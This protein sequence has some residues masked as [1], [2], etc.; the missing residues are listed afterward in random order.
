MRFDSRKA[1]RGLTTNHQQQQR[2][3]SKNRRYHRM[4]G[5]AQV[6]GLREVEFVLE[7]TNARSVHLAGDFNNWDVSGL[8]LQME[9]PGRWRVTVPLPP[10][11]HQY[12]FLVDGQWVDDQRACRIAPNPFGSCN[13]E[14]EVP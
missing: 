14:I 12:R 6:T 11:V 10:G 3:M 13:C 2:V 1:T 8:P 4:S 5:Q 7:T 9:S